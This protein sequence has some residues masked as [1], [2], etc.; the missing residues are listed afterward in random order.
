[1]AEPTLTGNE[2]LD[3]FAA[4][5]MQSGYLTPELKLKLIQ[6]RVLYLPV[7]GE[8][9]TLFEIR[10]DSRDRFHICTVPVKVKPDAAEKC[11]IKAFLNRSRADTTRP[12][13]Y[14]A[15]S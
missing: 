4:S 2:L 7:P 14:K 10:L 12:V 6:E 3:A 11:R 8:A 9:R 1:M 5:L 15:P 13:G